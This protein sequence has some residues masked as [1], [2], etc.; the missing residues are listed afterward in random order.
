MP[1]W[2]PLFV[3]PNLLVK[4]PVEVEY[5]ALVPPDDPRCLQIGKANSN[6]TKFLGSFT[7][8]FKR[9]V[10]PS[11][12]IVRADAPPW[13]IAIAAC[14][15]HRFVSNERAQTTILAIAQRKRIVWTN[16]ILDPCNYSLLGTPPRMSRAARSCA[17]LAWDEFCKIRSG[18]GNTDL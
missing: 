10:I 12:L 5:V 8:A 16:D 7:D 17:Q 9:K 15:P 18:L 11:A 3:L 2:I 14:K 13:V 1:D 4:Q 6:F